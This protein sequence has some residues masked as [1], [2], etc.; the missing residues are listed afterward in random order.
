MRYGFQTDEIE[1]LK[2]GQNVSV[3][4][5]AIE[6]SDPGQADAEK[7]EMIEYYERLNKSAIKLVIKLPSRQTEFR[8]KMA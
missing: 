5:N 4:T 1:S 8:S 2:V 3:W 6:E 7:I